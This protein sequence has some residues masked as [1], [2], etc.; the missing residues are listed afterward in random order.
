MQRLIKRVNTS[1]VDPTFH[2]HYYLTMLVFS[3]MLGQR[4]FLRIPQ[5]AN[6]NVAIPMIAIN[7]VYF[8]ISELI[9]KINEFES[10]SIALSEIN[11]S[12]ST[13]KTPSLGELNKKFG[14][15]TPL[16]ME[17][18]KL[19]PKVKHKLPHFGV[20]GCLF[21][22]RAF[23]QAS[24]EKVALWK[25]Q[26]FKPKRIISIT[27]GLGVDEWA[28]AQS[29]IEV[30]STD[31]QQDLNVLVRYNQR[32][33]CIEY[34]RH[35]LEAAELLN[36]ITPIANDL[37]YVDPDRRSEDKRLGGKWDVYSPNIAELFESFSSTF[38][39]WLIKLSPLT[40]INSVAEITQGSLTF[41]SIYFQHEVKELLVFIDFQGESAIKRIAVNLDA[42]GVQT[43]TPEEVSEFALEISPENNQTQFIFEPNGG[44][45]VLHFNDRFAQIEGI[46]SLTANATLFLTPVALPSHWG[47]SKEVRSTYTGSLNQI[48]KWLREQ[49]IQGAS[50]TPRSAKGLNGKQIQEKLGIKED[51][52]RVLFITHDEGT[53]HVWLCD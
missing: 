46:H 3:P 11:L 28:W 38:T 9:Y 26:T 22:Q 24:S 12:L 18:Y 48:K 21:L 15:F 2:L 8:M 50:V 39:K 27:G 14:E 51:S 42:Q 23:E 30:V 25:S 20:K 47:R 10:I 40:D 35:D 44:I 45:N 16:A 33:L 7:F 53:F 13:N 37:I 4:S 34:N 1:E 31:I 36:R 41:Y 5:D 32:K 29:G 6:I 19:L 49:Q 17:Q 52:S 43:T